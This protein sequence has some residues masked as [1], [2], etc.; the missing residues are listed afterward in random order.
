MWSQYGRSL[1]VNN[2]L[3]TKPTRTQ[4]HLKNSVVY[5]PCRKYLENNMLSKFILRYVEF[6]RRYVTSIQYIH[7]VR[8][9]NCISQLSGLG[10]LQFNSINLRCHQV[11][12]W[13][14]SEG[15]TNTSAM[16][17]ARFLL[18]YDKQFSCDSRNHLSNQMTVWSVHLS[19]TINSMET[20]LLRTL[21]RLKWWD[22]LTLVLI[23]E[24]VVIKL[25]VNS[26]VIKLDLVGAVE[27]WWRAFLSRLCTSPIEE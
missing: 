21:C 11:N 7:N 9:R 24:Q 1:K 2:R 3:D 26:L 14:V 13:F 17:G 20:L 12:V 22:M 16:K 25:Q 23:M 5:F 18:S 6:V 27:R 10:C 4:T 19:L 8:S 15:Y